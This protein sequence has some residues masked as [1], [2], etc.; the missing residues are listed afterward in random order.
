VGRA[1]QS[2]P[3]LP[4]SNRA[5][6]A[7]NTALSAFSVFGPRHKKRT[8]RSPYATKLLPGA[9]PSMP[10]LGEWIVC[11][12]DILEHTTQEVEVREE[13][14]VAYRRVSSPGQADRELSLPSQLAAIEAFAARR[15]LTIC[16]DYKEVA[17]AFNHSE[18]RPQFQAMIAHA[19]QDPT[20]TAVVVSDLSRL[21]RDLA[22]A[23]KTIRDLRKNGV[24][25]VSC[26][27]PEVDQESPSSVL[28]EAVML[29]VHEVYS[30]QIAQHTIRGQ[31]ENCQ[32]RD[33]ATGWCYVNGSSAPWGYRLE[34]VRRGTDRRGQPMVKTIWALDDRRTCGHQV[35]D[36]ARR[37][38]AYRAEGVTLNRL[39][40][41]L[42]DLGVPAPRK[43]AWRN[44]T[45]YYML[46]EDGLLRKAGIGVWGVHRKNGSRR[47]PSE[48]TVV[49]NAH[50]AL[51][52][53]SMAEQILT[54]GQRNHRKTPARRPRRLTATTG[55]LFEQ[56][57]MPMT[58]G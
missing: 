54:V 2:A 57:A 24:R 30:R 9:G 39:V 19:T 4:T 8:T 36:W 50:P 44:N 28:V 47:P 55:S 49:P 3:A 31:R 35:S 37:M 18:D 34:H 17:S 16:G 56:E 32:T 29:G 22:H 20:I 53:L 14:V 15:E 10:H 6:K 48:W 1:V 33:E 42:D 12:T 5:D 52:D 58:A 41:W 46:L 38:L 13:Y 23:E 21:D 51:I 45:L 27:E 25:V 26:T 43:G 40:E 11:L 7:G